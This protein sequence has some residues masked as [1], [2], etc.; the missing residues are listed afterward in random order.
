VLRQIAE[1]P[2]V[3]PR[4]ARR[5]LELCHFDPD[6]LADHGAQTCG[7]ACYACLLDY[8][9]QPDHKDLDRFLIRDLLAELSRAAC[10]PAGGAGSRAERMIALRH[11]CDSQIEKRWLDLVDDQML[12][13][14]SAAQHLI[15]SCATQPDFFYRE[16]HA[17][18][19]IDG[20]PHD[21]PEQIR[22]DDTITQC[23]MEAGY[24][25]I[26]F[27]HR[28]DWHEIFRRHPDIFGRLPT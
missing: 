24:I 22:K 26:R 12:R 28:A 6:T 1:D 10:R 13:P 9:N 11:R 19:Y 3:L 17:A 7:K 27:H 14:P 5:A 15:E 21:A 20:P 4:L 2:A 16:Y 23:L 18:I 8:G 25:V